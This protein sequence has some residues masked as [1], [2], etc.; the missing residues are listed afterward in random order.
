M[1]IE[2]QAESNWGIPPHEVQLVPLKIARYFLVGGAAAGVDF[3]LFAVL[4]KGFGIGWLS[5]GT[6]SFCIAT[7]A[8]YLLSIRHVFQSGARFGKSHELML[9]F[10]VSA[11]G[12]VTNQVVLALL[13]EGQGVDVLLSKVAATGS[14]FFWNYGA[15]RH[16][17]FKPTA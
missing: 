2:R 6:F 4:V 14:V 17:I 13:V 8:N 12:L 10:I 9:V 11:V 16:F 5:A 3:V 15:R 7:I 1:R